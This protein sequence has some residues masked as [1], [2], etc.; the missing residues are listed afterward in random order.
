MAILVMCD[1]LVSHLSSSRTALRLPCLMPMAASLAY[2]SALSFPA[3][4]WWA[5]TQQMVTSLPLAMILEHLSM[6]AA[7]K[8][9]LGPIPSVL[10]LSIA[11][12]GSTKTVY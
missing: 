9:W 6:A 5:G 1:R 12:V 8:N 10:I 7:A 2:S 3:T 11:E 4:P